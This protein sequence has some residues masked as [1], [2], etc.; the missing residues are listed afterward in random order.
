MANEAGTPD[1]ADPRV[2]EGRIWE[3]LCDTLREA[4]AHV[5][6]KDLPATPLERAAG[7]RY[8]T[9]FLAAGINFCVAH[10]DPDHPEL[11][12]MMDLNM[13]WGLDSPDCLYLVASLR[14]DAAYRLW[15]DPGT[16]N[17][18]DI[19]INAGHYAEG[20]IEAL[21]TI[22]SLSGDDLERREDGSVEVFLGGAERPGSWLPLGEG[23]RFVQLR[24][25][26]NDWEH[27][28]PAELLIERLGGPVTRPPLRTDQIALRIDLLRSWM[29]KGGRLWQ[30][31]S[32]VMRS[33]QPNTVFTF[34][35][36]LSAERSGLKGQAYCQGNFRCGPDEAVLFEFAPPP[37]R[38]WNI[39]LANAY[40]EAIDFITRQSSLNGH[41]AQLDPDGM[42][43]AVI[44]QR[45]PGVP[46]WLDP[47]G[48]EEGT[49][50]ARFI[51]AEGELPQP[52]A[53]VLQLTELRAAL[54][55]STPTVT[56][57]ARE[58]CLRRRREALWRRYRR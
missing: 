58:A 28:R 21:R 2:L 37:C 23:A 35:P 54:P 6:R 9:Q 46:N 4:G 25:N 56:A 16:A 42:F 39:S 18:L 3:E 19:Q 32:Q 44:A 52:S 31:M 34:A 33:M 51:L 22:G 10:A 41:Q 40:W 15:G 48:H 14:D 29:S 50:I 30:D 27:E 38:H 36:E 20:S 53:R 17:H 11:T 47:G 43:R 7:H 26:F 57:E 12:R 24:Q 13:R 45:D 49:L 8:L 1:P 5:L 55:D